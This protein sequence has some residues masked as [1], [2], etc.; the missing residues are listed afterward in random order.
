MAIFRTTTE[1]GSER[2]VISYNTISKALQCAGQENIFGLGGAY[3][4]SRTNYRI[5][6][7]SGDI[8][9]EWIFETDGLAKE[10][11]QAIR[12][13]LVEIVK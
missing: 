7:L 1:F 12:H 13:L 9:G 3:T 5:I 8:C 4:F 2:I 6:F 10:V 11:L